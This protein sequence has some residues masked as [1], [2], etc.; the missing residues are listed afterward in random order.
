M[1]IVRYEKS[2]SAGVGSFRDVEYTVNE[3]AS[4]TLDNAELMREGELERLRERIEITN[5]FVAELVQQLADSG[6]LKAGNL[7]TLLGGNFKVQP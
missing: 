7:A 5:A 1:K 3:A 4:S 2:Y 6:A